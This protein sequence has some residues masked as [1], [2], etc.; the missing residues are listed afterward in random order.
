MVFLFLVSIS[1]IDKKKKILY[2]SYLFPLN[3]RANIIMN[4][5]HNCHVQSIFRYRIN[6]DI[7]LHL[8]HEDQTT[9]YFQ[10]QKFLFDI[11]EKLNII[12]VKFGPINKKKF[13]VFQVH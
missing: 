2:I 7:F 9:F 4:D 5:F 10:R 6:I 13:Q 1:V 3:I 12:S 11:I 8:F